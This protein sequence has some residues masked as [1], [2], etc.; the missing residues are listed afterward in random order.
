M[1][2]DLAKEWGDVS[3]VRGGR[4]RGKIIGESEAVVGIEQWTGFAVRPLVDAE[5]CWTETVSFR[6]KEGR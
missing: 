3:T 5:K 6:P 4:G 1:R 2:S